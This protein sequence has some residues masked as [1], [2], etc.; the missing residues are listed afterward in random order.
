MSSD[1]SEL[2]E[3]LLRLDDVLAEAG[4]EAMLLTELDGFLCAI[5]VSPTPVAKDEYWPFDWAADERGVL[6]PGFD[7]LEALVD[8]R[9]ADIEREL[10]AGEYGPLYEVDDDTD[11]IVWQAWISGFQ[12]AMLLRFDAWDELLRDTGDD[13]RGEAAMGLA[14]G[15]MLADPANHPDDTASDEDWAQYDEAMEAMPE[16]LAQVAVL[17]YRLHRQE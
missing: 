1:F 12:E 11:E 10:A 13:P 9:L 5:A 14:T 15:L 4:D 16:I 2:P 8:A 7:E 6:R 3:S 17:L